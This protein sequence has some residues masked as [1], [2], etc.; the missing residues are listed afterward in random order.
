[1]VNGIRFL[2]PDSKSRDQKNVY[3]EKHGLVKTFYKTNNE[4]KS[5]DKGLIITGNSVSLG[6]PLIERGKYKNTFVN[7][8]EKNLR[9]NNRFYCQNEYLF[10]WN[11]K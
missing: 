6:H 11:T 9:E 8:L 10:C 2:E 1:M 4:N 5:L 7:L 3:I